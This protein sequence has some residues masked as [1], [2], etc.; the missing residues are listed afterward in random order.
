MKNLRARHLSSV[1]WNLL[2]I[3]VGALV[4]AIGVKAIVVDKGFVTGGITGVALLA[5][6]LSDALSPGIWYFI[7]NIP[8]FAVGGALVSRRFFLYSIY[9]MIVSS[10]F[11][12]LIRFTIP[13]HDPF[14]AVLAG[15]VVVGTGAGICF[16]SLGSLGGNDIVAIVL[17]QKF[18]LRMGT[19][20]SPSIWCS[21]PSASTC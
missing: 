19:F 13:V 15:G 17:H 4:F 3:T 10:L 1:S 11:M 2:L 9:G 5:Y 6:Y 12:S 14:L 21:S 20:S 18:N 16:H 8:L 7:I